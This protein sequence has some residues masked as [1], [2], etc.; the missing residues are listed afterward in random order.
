RDV[1]DAGDRELE[2][3]APPT[4]PDHDEVRAAAKRLRQTWHDLVQCLSFADV[5]GIEDCH[6]R[7]TLS[8]RHWLS[9]TGD[10]EL[11]VDA[12]RE[13]RTAAIRTPFSKVL[14]A[15]LR[16]GSLSEK[17][18]STP[19]AT[20]LMRSARLIDQRSS[21]ASNWRNGQAKGRGN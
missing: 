13:P 4:V 5:A 10:E 20:R 12:A 9:G 2:R 18:S 21:G 7:I 3:R 1:V 11:V 14:R 15:H 6:A 8:G 19:R 17:C 16:S